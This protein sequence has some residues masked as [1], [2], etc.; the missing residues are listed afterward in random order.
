MLLRASSVAVG[1]QALFLRA[2]EIWRYTPAPLPISLCMGP[3]TRFCSPYLLLSDSL[4]T[5]LSADAS[6]RTV[7][8]A[9]GPSALPLMLH[10]PTSA[11][12]SL[13]MRLTL[14][15][16]SPVRIGVELPTDLRELERRLY[17]RSV[18]PERR[19]V[20]EPASLQGF[21][22]RRL[23]FLLHASSILSRRGYALPNARVIALRTSLA[24]S[25][26]ESR[27]VGRVCRPGTLVPQ[28]LSSPC[29]VGPR[30][31]CSVLVSARLWRGRS[32]RAG[33]W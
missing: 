2:G 13:L 33:V 31:E 9:S 7:P 27:A 10:G 18:L 25:R 12:P 29:R 22:S 14:P 26:P 24:A 4:A 5:E 20:H 30:V 19:Q 6:S 16:L 8:A 11:R 21:E 32:V 15:V 17:R 1:L 23:F 28:A 3:K